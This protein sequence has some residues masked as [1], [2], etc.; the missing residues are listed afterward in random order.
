MTFEHLFPRMATRRHRSP[1]PSWGA[2]PEKPLS[3]RDLARIDIHRPR[4]TRQLQKVMLASSSVALS[5]LL[6]ACGATSPSSTSATSA[7]KA[8]LAAKPPKPGTDLNAQTTTSTCY[9]GATKIVFWSWVPG[10]YRPINLFNETHP[11]VC[12]DW[13]NTAAYA[14]QKEYVKLEAAFKADSGVPDVVQIT[15]GHLSDLILTKHLLNLVPYGADKIKNAYV[16][17]VWKIVSPFSNHDVY[18]IPQ[19]S[20]PMGLLY[21]T[22]LFKKYGLAIPRTWAQFAS[23]AAVVHKAH[24][25]VYLANIQQLTEIQLFWWQTGAFPVKWQGSANLTLNYDQPAA[26]KAADYWQKLWSAGDLANLSGTAETT[27]LT[28][29]DVLSALAPAW[30]PDVYTT[31]GKTTGE[32]S[33]ALLPQWT[34]GAKDNVND[35][36]STD[37]VTTNTKHPKQAAEFAIWLNSTKASWN[38]MVKPPILLF[39]TVKSVLAESSFADQKIPLTG[40]E[41]LEKVYGSI[42]NTVKTDWQWSP[43]QQYTDT[44]I[45]DDV[46]LVVEHKMTFAGLVQNVQKQSVAYAKSEGFTVHT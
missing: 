23:E 26:V 14:G 2:S 5:G 39:P 34:A 21:N 17:W 1:G 44:V 4:P 3:H 37:A 38:L 31:P 32:W 24:P 29:G 43:V 41:Q 15:Q 42:A 11:K 30:Y 6:A 36:G 40:S 16:P 18:S 22:S 28:R 8:P 9:S 27:A 13:V 45:T 46:D 12:V 25:G 33:I 7:T 35:G 19:D 10:I 20:G